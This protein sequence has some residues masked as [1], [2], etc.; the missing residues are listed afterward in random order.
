[1]QPHEL[2][3]IAHLPVPENMIQFPLGPY[4]SFLSLHRFRSPSGR[5]RQKLPK[6]IILPPFD[7]PKHFKNRNFLQ[8]AF[9]PPFR[10]RRAMCRIH[11]NNQLKRC[12]CAGAKE[13][14]RTIHQM[15]QHG[16]GFEQTSR[17]LQQEQLQNL[18]KVPVCCAP[19]GKKDD[20]RA[21]PLLVQHTRYI[22]ICVQQSVEN[23]H[24]RIID[25][26]T[27]LQKA[28]QQGT[29]S[30]RSCRRSKRRQNLENI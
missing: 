3:E 19:R 25:A 5:H 20:Q 4:M 2:Q 22:G 16:V 8:P 17:S 15:R 12:N 24:K 1:M 7:R 26:A 10:S 29:A 23:A 13:L 6:Q 18:Q 9:P 21:S 27:G 28:V 11:P 30:A 14:C